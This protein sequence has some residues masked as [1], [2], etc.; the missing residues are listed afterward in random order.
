M[1]NYNLFQEKNEL[2]KR[3]IMDK[4]IIELIQN[5]K[6][7]IEI[8]T[9]FSLDDENTLSIKTLRFDKQLNTIKNNGFHLSDGSIINILVECVKNENVDRLFDFLKVE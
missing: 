7:I 1:N 5:N 8:S 9:N 4:N 2:S 6:N 3:S